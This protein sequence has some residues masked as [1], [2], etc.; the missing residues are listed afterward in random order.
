VYEF[1]AVDGVS[2]VDH[3]GVMANSSPD[4]LQQQLDRID[5][6]FDAISRELRRQIWTLSLFGLF[7][8]AVVSVAVRL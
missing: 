7:L 4:T 1:L 6:K 8:V 2:R 5:A 3:D